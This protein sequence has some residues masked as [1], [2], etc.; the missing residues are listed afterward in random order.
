[1]SLLLHD[2]HVLPIIICR[3]ACIVLQVPEKRKAPGAVEGRTHRSLAGVSN[4]DDSDDDL[5]GCCTAH[6]S[7]RKRPR[8]LMLRL[9]AQHSGARRYST[10]RKVC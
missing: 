8:G 4:S 3:S 6:A 5:F 7:I 2:P 1:M 9:L 10:N